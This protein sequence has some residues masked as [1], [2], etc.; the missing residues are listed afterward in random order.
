M[1]AATN[2]VQELA[3][4]NSVANSARAGRHPETSAG[5]SAT[6]RGA[7][8]S[9]PEPAQDQQT[10]SLK[11]RA[12][13]CIDVLFVQ[14]S[15]TALAGVLLLALGLCVGTVALLAAPREQTLAVACAYPAMAVTYAIW[16][17]W[18]RAK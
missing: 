14:T 1:L 7:R 13:N 3:I 17:S 4:G 9:R 5:E 10:R 18:L 6:R 8:R 11:K 2:G 16:V 15:L 12:R